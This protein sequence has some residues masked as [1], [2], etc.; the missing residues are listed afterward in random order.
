MGGG[1]LVTTQRGVRGVCLSPRYAGAALVQA[2]RSKGFTLVELMIAIAILAILLGIGLPAYRDLIA[3]QR[4]RTTIMD[5]HSALALTRSEAI[6]RNRTVTLT[7]KDGDWSNGWSIANPLAGQPAILDHSQTGGVVI[8]GGPDSISFNASGR[9]PVGAA[10]IDFSVS[11]TGNSDDKVR[12]LCVQS[13][14]RA[15]SQSEECEP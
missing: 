11:S 7:P 15:D 5:L 6:K 13:D 4:V 1:C 9:P 2:G 8:E 10:G 12:H 14:G 3:Q